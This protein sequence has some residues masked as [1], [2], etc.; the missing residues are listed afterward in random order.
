MTTAA[1]AAQLPVGQLVPGST[2]WFWQRVVIVSF[3]AFLSV[4]AAVPFTA[5][6][7]H[8]SESNAEAKAWGIV[9]VS[10]FFPILVIGFGAYWAMRKTSLREIAQG[11]TTDRSTLAHVEVRDRRGQVIPP[12][13]RR[14]SVARRT[15]ATFLIL[16]T[17]CSAVAP[18]LWLARLML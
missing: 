1:R 15:V 10:T 9:F 11:Y 6:A 3:G 12:G 5:P 16:G 7:F 14:L 2:V 17:A 4:L 13:D 8:S 18:L